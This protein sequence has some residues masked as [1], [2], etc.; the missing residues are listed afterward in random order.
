ME[1]PAL[2]RY[3]TRSFSRLAGRT[4]PA[5]SGSSGTPPRRLLYPATT[6]TTTTTTNTL[7]GTVTAELLPSAG[8]TFRRDLS[9]MCS[10]CCGQVKEEPTAAG[11]SV[12][13]PPET[14][15]PAEGGETTPAEKRQT[16]P[17]VKPFESTYEEGSIGIRRVRLDDDDDVNET[18]D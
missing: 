10:R 4:A 13:K 18:R 8:K 14:S 3:L 16:A 7:T 6:M 1:Y 2:A 9:G 17:V 5:C 15:S 11:S 12:E